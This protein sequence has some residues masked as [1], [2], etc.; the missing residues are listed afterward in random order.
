MPTP[1]RTWLSASSG[2][3]TACA[4]SWCS[5]RTTP[6]GCGWRNST[7]RWRCELRDRD[8]GTPARADRGRARR[9]VARAAWCGWRGIDDRDAGGARSPTARCTCRARSLPPLEPGEFYVADLIGCAV[10]GRRRARTVGVVRQAFWNGSQ[11]VLEIRDQAGNEL[12]IPAVARF[13]ARGGCDGAAAGD[14][15]RRWCRGRR[16][17]RSDGG[18][19][20]LIQAALRDPH[21][22]PGAVRLVPGGQPAGQGDRGRAGGRRPHQPARLRAGQAPLGR[23]LALRRRAR[24]W[25]MR[26]EPLAAAIEAIEAARGPCHRILLSPQGRLFDQPMA[27]GAGAAPA[28][29]TDVRPLR[30][31]RR[32]GGRAVRPRRRQHR[33]LRA[34]GGRGG[35]GGDHRG[36]RPP[37]ARA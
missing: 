13:P 25:C 17:H 29:P 36:G 20:A 28:H 6:R 22:V 19:D 12:L 37:G 33:R 34:V 9:S 31:H 23:R 30:G 7:C 8:G 24:A 35:G 15:R 26:P 3:R 11:D 1:A 32:S 10:R 16:Q 14:R 2:A 5:A 27:D 21:A 4:A 18:G